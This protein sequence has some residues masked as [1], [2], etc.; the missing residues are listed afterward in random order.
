MAGRVVPNMVH[1]FFHCGHTINIAHDSS[2]LLEAH[3][4]MEAHYGE[5]HQDT[6]DSI[7]DQITN[8]VRSN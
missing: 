3:D 5:R 6:I 2:N 4:E 8:S 1:C 7:N